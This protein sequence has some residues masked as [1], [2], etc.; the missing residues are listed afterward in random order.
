VS[1]DQLKPQDG[2]SDGMAEIDALL[3]ELLV[4]P[5][6]VK[7]DPATG[8]VVEDDARDSSTL[9]RSTGRE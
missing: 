9:D 6:R 8:R 5:G 7:V 1:E 3:R 2:S 4:G